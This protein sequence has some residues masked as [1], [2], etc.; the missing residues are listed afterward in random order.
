MIPGL[1]NSKHSKA[2]S[3]AH[4]RILLK[5]LRRSHIDKKNEVLKSRNAL[6][7]G[8]QNALKG[9]GWVIA[10]L[11]SKVPLRPFRKSITILLR[12][13]G[14][15]WFGYLKGLPESTSETALR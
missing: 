1:L 10:K 12:I 2:F 11:F 9:K 15:D 3:H 7:E 5:A 6:L 14:Y 4:L 8:S 13:L